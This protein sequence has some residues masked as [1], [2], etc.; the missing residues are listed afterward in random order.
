MEKGTNREIGGDGMRRVGLLKL[1][2]K[3]REDER[4]R[5]ERVGLR[6]DRDAKD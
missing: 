3:D 1:E 6:F 2:G 5:D 4:R